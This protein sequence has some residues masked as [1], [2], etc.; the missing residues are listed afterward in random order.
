MHAPPRHP[1]KRVVRRVIPALLVAAI[2][3]TAIKAGPLP[4]L[5]DDNR[6][7][8]GSRRLKRL[9]STAHSPSWRRSS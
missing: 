5:L 4:N 9:R 2:M 6:E 7:T 8:S 3:A 1:R